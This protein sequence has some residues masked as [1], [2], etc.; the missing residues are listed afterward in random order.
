MN[1]VLGSG[2]TSYAGERDTAGAFTEVSLPLADTVD[3]RAAARADEYDDVGALHARRL[4]IEYRP[5]GIVTLRG[6]LSTGDSAPSMNHLHS[7]ASQ[8]HPYVRC[9]QRVGR[10]RVRATPGTGGR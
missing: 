3:V 10:R 8:D 5:S 6:S 9:V 7:T 4:G 1:G 2:G